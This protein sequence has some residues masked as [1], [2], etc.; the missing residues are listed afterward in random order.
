MAHFFKII[1][2]EAEDGPF[3]NRYNETERKG[4]AQNGTKEEKRETETVCRKIERDRYKQKQREWVLGL[5]IGRYA[6]EL[7]SRR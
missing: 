6:M 5:N 4:R 1:G 7:F 2:I 3:K